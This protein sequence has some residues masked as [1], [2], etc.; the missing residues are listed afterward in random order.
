MNDKQLYEMGLPNNI[1][2]VYEIFNFGGIR[3][4]GCWRVSEKDVWLNAC[5]NDGS[6]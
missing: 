5:L 6:Q 2:S 3:G 4:G 1:G